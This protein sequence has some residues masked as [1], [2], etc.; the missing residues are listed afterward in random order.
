MPDLKVKTQFTASGNYGAK[1]AVMTTKTRALSMAS[2]AASASMRGLGKATMWVG[3][4][5]FG[6][7]KLGATASLVTFIALSAAITRMAGSMDSLAKQ[8]RTVDFPIEQFQEYRFAAEQSGIGNDVFGKSTQKLAKTIGE[9][10]GGYGTLF[11]ALRKSD[12]GLLKSLRSTKDTKGAMDLML[13][14]IREIE[15]PMKKAALASAAFGRAGIDMINMANLSDRELSGLRKQMRDNGVVTAEQAAKAEEFNDAMNRTKLTIMGV[16]REGLVPLMPLASKYADRL[17]H[18]LILNRKFVQVK[19]KQ[20]FDGV[21]KRAKEVNTWYQKNRES[22]NQLWQTGKAFAKG[23]L[24]IGQVMLENKNAILATVAAL[25][26]LRAALGTLSLAQAVAGSGAAAGASFG[27]SFTAAA[28]KTIAASAWLTA[29]LTA[30]LAGF[31]IGSLIQKY[32]VEEL[33]SLKDKQTFKNANQAL[34]LEQQARQTTSLNELD[35]MAEIV[36]AQKQ[37]L[38]SHAGALLLGRGDD[39][40]QA[41]TTLQN[42]E[43]SIIS[44]RQ[45]VAQ[46]LDTGQ[47][48]GAAPVSTPFFTTNTTTT[49]QKHELVIRDET[50]RAEITKGKQGQGVTLV[51]TGAMP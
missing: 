22:L 26:T 48:G 5:A 50:G 34:R 12:R 15:D 7:L 33:Q 13:N 17:R 31:A 43:R 8:A 14:K 1:V 18:W 46:E 3:R 51:T 27:S 16:A 44:Q 6:A 24:Q 41:A 38:G 20:F 49:V 39:W 21:I 23:A 28:S 32:V 45:N 19:I 40:K 37:K 2:K 9:L 11:T 47:S 4:T 29:G 10:K 35:K 42:V 36:K 30:A 25:A